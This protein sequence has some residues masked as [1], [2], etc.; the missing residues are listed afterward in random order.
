MN[1]L[2]SDAFSIE[3]GI[4]MNRCQRFPLIIDPQG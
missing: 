2:P 3:N 1:Y 4:I